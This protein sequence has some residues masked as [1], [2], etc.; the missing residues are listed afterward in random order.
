MKF[1]TDFADQAVILPLAA[2]VALLLAGTRWW[3]GLTAWI[4]T[5]GGVLGTVGIMKAMCVACR[6]PLA[7]I[8]LHSPSGHTASAAIVFGGIAILA[9]SKNRRPI[10]I[11]APLV[12][13]IVFGATRLFL[14]VHTVAD[15]LVG[16]VVGVIGALFLA[17]LIGSD[18]PIRRWNWSLPLV[19]LLLLHG[20]HL[21][22]EIAIRSWAT[23][24]IPIPAFCKL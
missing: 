19:V 3:R 20:R 7:S 10:V 11:F 5:V 14:Q 8:D 1:L 17:L 23:D 13:A 2:A 22:A 15:V 6:I 4:L 21:P 18:V 24:F 16:G 9:A 12:C